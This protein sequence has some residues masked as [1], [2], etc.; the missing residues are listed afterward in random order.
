MLIMTGEYQ[1]ERPRLDEL[2]MEGTRE[3]E[4]I[5]ADYREVESSEEKSEIGDY[6]I[7]DEPESY[8]Y[9]SDIEKLQRAY[10]EGRELTEEEGAIEDR[11]AT[12]AEYGPEMEREYEEYADYEEEAAPQ[13][14]PDKLEVV[15]TDYAKRIAELDEDLRTAMEILVFECS[16]YTPFK[17]FLPILS[18]PLRIMKRSI[19]PREK[20][21]FLRRNLQRSLGNG[22]L[23]S[24]RTWNFVWTV[25]LIRWKIWRGM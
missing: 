18:V 12:M 16:C 11:L 2:A 5:D 21:S 14:E 20:S 24:I 6:A 9:L 8:E 25:P 23:K 15:P 13:E 22:N 19:T 3:D 7:P 17:P 10:D 1:P 4:I